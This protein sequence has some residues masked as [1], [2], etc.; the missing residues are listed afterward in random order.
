MYNRSIRWPSTPLYF[1]SIWCV[2]C[3]RA[4]SP[5][6]HAGWCQTHRPENDV[7]THIYSSFHARTLRH[8]LCLRRHNTELVEVALDYGSVLAEFMWSY[9]GNFTRSYV[10]INDSY[11]YRYSL[12]MSRECEIDG[13]G[14]PI[15]VEGLTRS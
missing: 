2:C 1:P 6:T 11:G 8:V 9:T 5:L 10:R 12:A 15:A 13:H 4:I 7:I 3:Y 14:V